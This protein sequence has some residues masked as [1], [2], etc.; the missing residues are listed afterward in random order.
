M[1][2]GV[3]AELSAKGEGEG[4]LIGYARRKSSTCRMVGGST[5]K[6]IVGTKD[7]MSLNGIRKIKSVLEMG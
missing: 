2:G 7:S 1:A 6:G 3:A 4:A 5:R